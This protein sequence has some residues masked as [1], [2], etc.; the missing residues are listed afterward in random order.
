MLKPLSTLL[1]SAFY[2]Q[3]VG[4]FL[5]L[6]SE[7]DID[8][9]FEENNM[10]Y[11]A[12][13]FHESEMLGSKVRTSFQHLENIP[14]KTLAFQLSYTIRITSNV[15]GFS[16]PAFSSRN[17]QVTECMG[18]SFTAEKTSIVEL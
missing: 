15:P 5:P 8:A 1:I 2:S 14:L 9:L 17:S 6:P 10:L 16:L 12:V 18:M 4:G 7:D 11:A 13:I 3:E